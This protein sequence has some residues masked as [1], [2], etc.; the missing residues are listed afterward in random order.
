MSQAPNTYF[1]DTVD[2]PCGPLFL[3]VDPAGRVVRISF[4]EGRDYGQALRQFAALEARVVEEPQRLIAV[5]RQLTEYFDRDRTEFALDLAPQGSPFQLEVWRALQGIPFGATTSYGE[6]A[7]RI[8]RPKASRAV[9]AANGAN[10][11]PIVVPCHRVIGADGSLTGFGG[12]LKAKTT[13]LELEGLT[14]SGNQV[15][16]RQMALGFARG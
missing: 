8:G 15:G 2:S 11:I 14:V 16:G 4:V 3:A 7:Q 1:T 13:L 6:I 9:G 12:G 5:K 10:P